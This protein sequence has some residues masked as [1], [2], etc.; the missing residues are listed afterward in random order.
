LDD[1]AQGHPE[2]DEAAAMQPEEDIRLRSLVGRQATPPGPNCPALTEWAS[3]A[4]G[5]LAARRRDEMLE[6]ASHCDACGAT[7][8]A[9]MED[10]SAETTDEEQQSLA[11]LESSHP[12]WQG[13]VARRMSRS[14]RGPAVVMMHSWLARAAA[15]LLAV[16]GG[17]FA[18][19]SSTAG[20]PAKLLAT[21]FTEK[22]PFEFRIPGAAFAPVSQERGGGSLFQQPQ[23]L[24]QAAEK[25]RG[26][27]TDHPDDVKYLELA[28]RAEMMERDP[29]A[30]IE[31]LRHALELKPDDADLLAG[32]GLAYALLQGTEEKQAVDY[33]YAMN[34]LVQSLQKKPNS[35]E[36][37]FN[38]AL[39]Y[40]K[41]NSLDLARGAWE[42]YLKA[43]PAGAWSVDA[44]KH[45]ADLEQKKKPVRQP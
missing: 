8:C 6:H 11:R 32:L 12:E 38:L 44:Q 17:W 41:M 1:P 39:V 10:F 18:Y 28:A 16:G 33:G 45:L 42:Q 24:M 27:L 5:L 26:R 20:D 29:Q 31:R 30:A 35:P 37:L 36:T 34:Y 15:V 9:V 2:P 4:G 19:T 22:R 13:N 3:L 14:T 7:L 40:E 25:I 21:A 43:D 23:A